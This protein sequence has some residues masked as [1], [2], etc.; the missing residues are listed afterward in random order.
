MTKWDKEYI[1]F[2]IEQEVDYLALS[3]VRTAEDV[4]C[5][6]YYTKAYGDKEIPIIAK[7]EKPQAVENLEEIILTT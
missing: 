5:A 2:A 6:R 4:K 1:K 3:F 7:I